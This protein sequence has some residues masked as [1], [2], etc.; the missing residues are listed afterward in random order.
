MSLKN[1]MFNIIVKEVCGEDCIKKMYNC[2]DW[3]CTDQ[4]CYEIEYGVNQFVL[5]FIKTLE[6]MKK[7]L[8][9]NLVGNTSVL[10]ENSGYNNAL[11]DIINLFDETKNG[12]NNV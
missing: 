12:E 11:D 7:A 6:K 1:I 5:S 9:N 2:K 10:I 8:P 3:T 4:N